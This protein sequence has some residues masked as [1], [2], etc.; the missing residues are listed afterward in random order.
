MGKF[1]VYLGIDISFGPKPVTLVA[2][3]ENQ[4]AIAIS[5]GDTADALAFAAGQTGGALAAINAAARPNRERMKREEVRGS[6]SP[7]P[8]K[9]K[10]TQ[11]R[12]VE[13][14]LIQAGIEVRHTSASAGRGLPSVRRGFALIEKL[15]EMG[16]VP[17]PAENALHQWLEVPA[18]AAIGSLL[19][20]TPLPAGTLEGRI[21]RQLALQD[22]GLNVPDAMDFFEEITRYRLL[23]SI[24]PTKGIFPQAELNAWTAAHT[25]WLADHH[26]E[27]VRRFG[28]EEEGLVFLPCKSKPDSER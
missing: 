13:Y 3:D 15:E 20:V 5:S 18:D 22:Q 26:P 1:R 9:G 4:Q 12:Q 17:F 2:L 16:Y 28:E 8:A 23:K 11:L 6:L 19:G 10:Y 27:Q 24:L 21:Q 25:A 7:A 14:E